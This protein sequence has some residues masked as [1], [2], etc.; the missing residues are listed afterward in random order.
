[1]VARG[2]Q[3]LRQLHAG[4]HGQ[5]SHARGPAGIAQAVLLLAR[6]KQQSGQQDVGL[7]IG[8]RNQAHL[9]GPA[10]GGDHAV[11]QQAVDVAV[12]VAAIP[13]GAVLVEARLVDGLDGVA[14]VA[15]GLVDR[16]LGA[17]ALCLLKGPYQ[18]GIGKKVVAYGFRVVFQLAFQQLRDHAVDVLDRV[19]VARLT[20]HGEQLAHVVL[21]G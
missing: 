9:A 7:D 6:G 15:Y 10:H 1:M 3:A 8:F 20:A 5:R 14:K 2:L 16:S 21:G 17:E 13:K 19:G 18:V 12:E 4:R 11:P